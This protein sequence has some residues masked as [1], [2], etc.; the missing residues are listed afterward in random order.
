MRKKSILA[1][2][3]MG[4]LALTK[5]QLSQSLTPSLL[6]GQIPLLRGQIPLLQSQISLLRSQISLL[7]SQ[8]S[9]LRSQISFLQGQIS[10]LEPQISSL[11]FQKPLLGKENLFCAP[12]FLHCNRE[13][14]RNPFII[15]KVEQSLTRNS[16]TKTVNLHVNRPHH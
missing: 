9:L 11:Q 7:Q 14:F 2:T 5:H 4:K 15:N 6:R 3:S 8:I 1:M 12:D 10:S 16:L 13:N